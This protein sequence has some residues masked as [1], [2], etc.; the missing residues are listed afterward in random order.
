MQSAFDNSNIV[1][2]FTRVVSL[3]SSPSGTSFVCSA[4]EDN[5][6]SMSSVLKH[7][8]STEQERS[9]ENS[10]QGTLLVWDLKKM[11]LE[12]CT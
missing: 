5:R 3:A 8:L 10:K 7:A 4:V 1:I 6:S 2:C 11:K 12:V 9:I